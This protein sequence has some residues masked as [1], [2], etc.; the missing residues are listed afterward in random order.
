MHPSDARTL[1][2]SF[3][4]S[5]LASDKPV[6]LKKR[7]CVHCAALSRSSGFTARSRRTMSA[8]S[9]LK[10]SSKGSYFP[11]IARYKPATLCSNGIRPETKRYIK[12]PTA[13]ISDCCPYFPRS[14][15]SGA[16]NRLV[17]SG[18]CLSRRSA[19]SRCVAR[20]KSI[21]VRRRGLAAET[22]T[23]AGFRSRYTTPRECTWATASTSWCS[24]LIFSARI[25][26]SGRPANASSSTT[27]RYLIM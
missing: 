22:M 8:A 24:R 27:T 13:H 23:F 5:L 19:R 1:R 2:G 21:R 14:S 7:C 18:A 16:W 25:F 6:L 15:T 10:A 20:P 9:G 11:A 12:T 26:A 4:I 17:P 3:A